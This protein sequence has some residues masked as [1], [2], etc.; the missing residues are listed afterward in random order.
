MGMGKVRPTVRRRSRGGSAGRW[1]SGQRESL[2]C[3][4][5]VEGVVEVGSEGQ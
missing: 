1:A 3:V 4:G 5:G 2:G